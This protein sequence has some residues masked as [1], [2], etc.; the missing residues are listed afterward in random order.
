MFSDLAMPVG[1]TG[2]D[3]V[4]APCSAVGDRVAA[5]RLGAETPASRAGASTRP[6]STSSLNAL[7]TLVS[8]SPRPS[9]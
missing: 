7:S 5:G 2:R 3:L 4:G 8:S 6:I 9:G 1:F